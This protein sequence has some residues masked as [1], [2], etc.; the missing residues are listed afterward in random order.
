MSQHDERLTFHRGEEHA[1]PHTLSLTR[2][3]T[4]TLADVD[5]AD[6]TVVFEL[7]NPD[8]EPDDL[9]EGLIEQNVAD[10]E[11][12]NRH[13]DLFGL[14]EKP[15]PVDTS[16]EQTETLRVKLHEK[17]QVGDRV[18]QLTEISGDSATLSP[19]RDSESRSLVNSVEDLAYSP[20]AVKIEEGIAGLDDII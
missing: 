15:V 9:V 11:T 18:W 19:G 12:T 7:H 16:T 3:L 2:H 20:T 5:A 1:L 8:A 14:P 6:G 4:L 10:A 13:R 17:L